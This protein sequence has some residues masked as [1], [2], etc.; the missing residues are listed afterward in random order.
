MNIQEID[1]QFIN[2]DLVEKIG[3][4]TTGT[5][6]EK[7]RIIFKINGKWDE[8]LRNMYQY[9]DEEQAK[10]RIREILKQTYKRED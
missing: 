6:G 8:G 5:D 1:G 9:E 3:T 7:R 2:L 10:E 4:T